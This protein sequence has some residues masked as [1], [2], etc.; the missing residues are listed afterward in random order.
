MEQTLKKIFLFV[1]L[2]ILLTSCNGMSTL[3]PAITPTFTAVSTS[4]PQPASTA[5]AYQI[6]SITPTMLGICRYEHIAFIGGSITAGAGASESSKSYAKMVGKWFI[7]QCSNKI[8]IK[9][10]SIGGTGSDFAVYRLEHDLGNFIPDITFYEFAVN[11]GGRPPDDIKKH[12]ESLIYKLRRINSKMLIFS[13]LTT[14]ESHKD[15]YQAGT[16]PP[17]VDTYIQVASENN[18]P[19]INIGQSLWTY[20]IKNKKNIREYLSDGVHPNDAGYQLYYESVIQFLDSYFNLPAEKYSGDLANATLIDM[21][22]V[23]STTCEKINDNNEVHL[24]CDNG[25]TFS[26]L[27]TGDVLGLVG[28]IRSDGGRLEC[29]VDNFTKNTLDFW[30]AYAIKM[31]RTSYFFPFNGLE[32][33]N[34]EL[35]CSVLDQR[36]SSNAGESK[37]YAVH[38]LYF[39]VNP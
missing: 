29:M 25:D 13:V 6:S 37:G 10:I 17:V 28:R 31:D 24:L 39:M 7:D 35:I 4:T 32:K 1:N 8:H 11:D 18:I 2:M 16:L 9:N 3:Q 38:I 34:H 30:D 20:V 26:S 5:T 14:R 19:V 12:I 15:F 27:F 36:I 22:K 23:T 21:S 33:I